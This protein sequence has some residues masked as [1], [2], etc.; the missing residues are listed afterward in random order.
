MGLISGSARLWTGGIVPFSIDIDV[1]RPQ[2]PM[3]SAGIALFSASGVQLVSHNAEPNYV[4]F[5]AYPD[6]RN[7]FGSHSNIGRTGGPQIIWVGSGTRSS[8]NVAHEICHALGLLHEHNRLDR[9]SFVSINWGNINPIHHDQFKAQPRDRATDFGG[10]DKFSIMHYLRHAY[11]IDQNKDTITPIVS[12]PSATQDFSGGGLSLGD[13]AALNSLYPPSL[14]MGESSDTGPA[15]AVHRN[16]ILLA[17]KGKGNSSLA[18]MTS[19]TGTSFSGKANLSDQSNNA[20]ALAVLRN[21]FVIAWTGLGDNHLNVMQS[22]DGVSWQDKVTLSDFS[23]SP[24]ALARVGAEIFLS[25][26]GGDDRLNLRRSVDGIRWSPKATIN[27]TSS[28]GP[29]LGSAGPTLLLAWRGM[30]N[31]HINVIR[32]PGGWLPGIKLTLDDTTDDRPALCTNGPRAFLAWRGTGNGMM[33]MMRSND[34]ASWTSKRTVNTDQM[35]GGP[36]IAHWDGILVRCWTEFVSGN[37]LR[38]RTFPQF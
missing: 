8:S 36:S 21:K 20:P 33:N 15:L 19:S 2:R 25:W 24:P 22:N 28:S 10:Y 6:P 26:R 14:P 35:L 29:A 7:L 31:N 18:T 30:G 9:D 4:H 5:A 13:I 17:W 11:A 16:A 34:G 32:A 27:E 37:A 38:A 1:G 23:P 3:I 12:P